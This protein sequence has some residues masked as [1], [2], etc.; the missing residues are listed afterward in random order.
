M[1]NRDFWPYMKVAKLVSLSSIDKRTSYFF[2]QPNFNPSFISSSRLSHS[3]SFISRL[4]ERLQTFYRFCYVHLHDLILS[5]LFGYLTLNE[6]LYVAVHQNQLYNV[7][8]LLSHG[9]SPSFIPVDYKLIFTHLIRNNHQIK[10]YYVETRLFASILANDSMLYMA[11]SNNNF[12]LI[13]EL[14]T[15]HDYGQKRQHTEVISLCLAV[16]RGYFDIVKYLID[17]GHIDPNDCVKLS[18]KHCKTVKND[19]QR[20]QFPLYR[21]LV[22]LFD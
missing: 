18:C 3:S 6:K 11:V 22:F 15:Y 5:S 10:N 1:D 16:K 21:K 9:A 20:Y 8:Q 17:Y 7:R 12:N 2:S 14:I 19:N 13:K 4:L